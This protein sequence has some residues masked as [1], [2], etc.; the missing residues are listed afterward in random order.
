MFLFSES[1]IFKGM[2]KGLAPIVCYLSAQEPGNLMFIYLLQRGV[3]HSLCEQ[4]KGVSA[5]KKDQLE[6]KKTLVQIFAHLFTN[7]RL[8]L[9]W[10][11]EDKTT[12][13]SDGDSTVSLLFFFHK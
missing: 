9:S 12:Y 11:P 3:F 5:E 13:P 7:V 6:V 4:P 1:L 8:P 10:N 2:P